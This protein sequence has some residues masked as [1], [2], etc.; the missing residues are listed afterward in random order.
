MRYISSCRAT[1]LLKP[2]TTMLCDKQNEE[3][4]N[5]KMVAMKIVELNLNS[6]NE[7]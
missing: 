7:K 4:E 1:N 3:F 2:K 5:E 6:A